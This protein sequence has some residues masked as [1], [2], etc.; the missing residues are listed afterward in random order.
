[1]TQW[2]MTLAA[3]PDAPS[4]IPRTYRVEEETSTHSL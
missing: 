1:M 4:L 2:T 3:K